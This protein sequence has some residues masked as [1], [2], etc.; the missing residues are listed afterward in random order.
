MNT[1]Q[2]WGMFSPQAE[3]RLQN[4]MGLQ[5]WNAV[6]VLDFITSLP[7]VDPTK[8]AVTGASGGGTQTMILSG[9]DDRIAV[10][11]PAVMVS[12]AMQGGCTCENA[13]L[14]RVETGNVE[15]AGLFAP[16]PLGMTAANDWTKEMATKGFPELKELYALMGAPRNVELVNNIHFQ[17][18]YNYVNRSAFYAFIN[19]HFKLGLEEPVVEEDYDRLTRDQMTV[20]D[21]AHPKPESGPEFERKL[22]RQL[23]E[24]AKKQLDG[25][26][27]KDA[28]SL[29]KWREVVGGAFETIIGGSLPAKS[30]LLME[31]QGTD[32]G[33]YTQYNALL[34]NK[35]RGE[36]LPMVLL[37]PK[38]RDGRAVIWLAE[39]GKAALFAEDGSP[40]REVKR[41]LDAGVGVFGV[42]LLFQG[43][44]LPQGE[45]AE[46]NR[47]VKNPR[48]FA[49]YTYGYNYA[50]LAQRAHDVLNVIACVK[51]N[52][53]G[54]VSLV[55]SDDRGPK[56]VELIA[57]DGTAPIAAAA[58]A[59]SGGTVNRAALDTRGF[60][61]GKLTD[62]LD[63]S[64]LP[65]GAKYGD[66]P[67]LLSLAA[68]TKLWLAGETADSIAVAKKAYAAAGA[69]DA[70]AFDTSKADEARR[71]AV[72][73]LIKAQ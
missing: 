57:L 50:L 67:G 48:E 27:P 65:G 39:Q 22:C 42:D 47:N 26:T 46:K 31:A 59:L 41:L 43:E 18:N 35:S 6:R 8:V 25:L 7:D 17:H 45:P 71:A 21:A 68:P 12:T 24:A 62:Y 20:W 40:T 10:A 34:S 19:K 58:L 44:F 66:L 37:L 1:K 54:L 28:A 33:S 13:S 15:I 32:G 64:F 60:R 55:R 49:G 5:T 29:A 4:M 70:I 72:E 51:N 61:F 9:I 16:K 73:W 2:D 14:L 56:S 3:L 52:A 23:A 69:S 36:Q 53:L 11:M 38:N 30:D 63:A